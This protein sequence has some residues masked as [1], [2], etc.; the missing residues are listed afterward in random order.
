ML[1]CLELLDIFL[2]QKNQSVDIIKCAEN[3]AGKVIRVM[4]KSK[5]KRKIL[6]HILFGIGVLLVFGIILGLMVLTKS[7]WYAFVIVVIVCLALVFIRSRDIWRKGMPFLFWIGAI[8]VSSLVLVA[9]RPDREVS[10]RGTLFR[11]LFR[12][13]YITMDV[14]LFQPQQKA[15][16]WNAPEGYTNTTYSLSASSVDLLANDSSDGSK[17]IYMLHGGAYINGLTSVYNDIAVRYSEL[18][19][20]ADVALLDYRTAS[21]ALY[22]AALDDTYEGYE[23]L[24]KQG[25]PAENIILAGD[26]AGGNLALALTMRLRDEKQSLPGGIILMSPWTNI[27]GSGFSNI[28]NIYKD[29]LFGVKK[30]EFVVKEPIPLDYF[31]DSDLTDAYVSPAF[32]SYEGFPP[33]L[34]QV[35]TWEILNSDSIDVYKKAFDAGTEVTLT[36]YPGMFHTFQIILGTALPEGKAAWEEVGAFLKVLNSYDLWTK[37]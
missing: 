23:F 25:Y 11:E 18:S 1:F 28:E 6:N 5:G 9:G 22:P 35:G 8:V 10:F 19:G 21:K 4:G 27:T 13:A 7:K 33:M 17:V 3:S 20:G 2:I 34:I 16:I 24:L 15:Y 30:G 32:G 26:S 29:P 12:V 37:S 31:A 14:P 36:E